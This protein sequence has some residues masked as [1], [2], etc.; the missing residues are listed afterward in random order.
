MTVLVGFCSSQHSA[1]FLG[2][3]DLEGHSRTRREKVCFI[4]NRFLVGGLGADAAF[5]AAGVVGALGAEEV[6]FSDNSEHYPAADTA[7]LCE[8]I[9]EI[10]PTVARHLSKG[11]D[12]AIRDKKRSEEQAI[13]ATAQLSQ[14]VVID[15]S[16]Q[17]QRI[18]LA[19][20][21]RVYPPPN[22]VLPHVLEFPSDRVLRFGPNPVDELG[23]VPALA[24]SEPF[25]W[26]QDRL[27]EAASVAEKMGSSGM[28]GNLGSCYLV[29]PGRTLRRTIYRSGIDLALR[30]YPA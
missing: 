9:A 22:R 21:G 30:H 16:A 4:A 27:R 20:F 18:S 28:V 5:L 13:E 15:T 6:C 3:D 25:Q 12:D 17:R 1:S 29:S 10:I 26:C 11:L 14:L 8:Q 2:S 23:D 24:I 7:V 19:N